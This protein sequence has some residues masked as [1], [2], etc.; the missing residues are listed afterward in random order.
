MRVVLEALAGE[1]NLHWSSYLGVKASNLVSMR[2]IWG[3]AEGAHL[4]KNKNALPKRNEFR[5]LCLLQ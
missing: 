5:E 2:H 4:N 1:T 3:L